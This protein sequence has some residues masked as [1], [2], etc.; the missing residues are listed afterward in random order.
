MPTY[1]WFTSASIQMEFYE[2]AHARCCE[3]WAI[4]KVGLSADGQHVS[5]V[6]GTSSHISERKWIEKKAALQIPLV[7]WDFANWKTHLV[8]W[9]AYWRC[10][11]MELIWWFSS[12]QTVRL[13]TA[14]HQPSSPPKRWCGEHLSFS[15]RSCFPCIKAAI[16]RNGSEPESCPTWFA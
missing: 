15:V 2:C 6:G 11:D 5:L 12:L 14:K 16:M 3:P 13:S 1:G 7:L 9:C 10:C 4:S 8:G